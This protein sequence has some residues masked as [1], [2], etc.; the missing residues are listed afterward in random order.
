M[1][2][3]QRAVRLDDAER[4]EEAGNCRTFMNA[5]QRVDDAPDRRPL[6]DLLQ[7][8]RRSHDESRDEVALRPDECD[9]LRT[10]ADSGRRDRGGVLDLSADPKQVSVIAAEADDILIVAVAR[11]DQEVSVGD[12]PREGSQGQL[13]SGRLRHSLQRRVECARE[14][15]AQWLLIGHGGS[16]R[17]ECL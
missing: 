2:D 7:R 9:H 3:R 13:A 16:P 10:N 4:H 1:G 17:I 11:G 15:A 14:L 5:A 6:M 12:A 8:D